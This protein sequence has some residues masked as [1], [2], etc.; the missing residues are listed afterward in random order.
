M[1]G[2][3]GLNCPFAFVQRVAI[4]IGGKDA[5]A[6]RPIE[7]DMAGGLLKDASTCGE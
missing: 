6:V 7:D 3:I 4:R 1:D 5:S 2:S